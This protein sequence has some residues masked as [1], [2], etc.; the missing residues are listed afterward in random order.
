MFEKILW[1]CHIVKDL[2]RR[3]V[4]NDLSDCPLRRTLR[5]LLC[6]EGFLWVA[7]SEGF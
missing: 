2:S 6:W 3:G 5:G 1:G 4:D 7:V